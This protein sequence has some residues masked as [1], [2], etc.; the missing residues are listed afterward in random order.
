MIASFNEPEEL[1]ENNSWYCNVCKS[2]KK[3][4]KIMSIYK[5]PR[6]LILHLKRF[7]PKSHYR[8][9][10]YGEIVKT[11]ILLDKE[12]SISGHNY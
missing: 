7:N 9:M 3:I 12:Q 6:Y 1:T 4:Q 5:F 2:H 11:P 10:T 8:F